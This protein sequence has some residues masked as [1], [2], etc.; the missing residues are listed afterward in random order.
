MR[1]GKKITYMRHTALLVFALTA[2][3]GC[4]ATNSEVVQLQSD[5]AT[6]KSQ[7]KKDADKI[8][9]LQQETKKSKRQLLLQGEG[10]K[11]E[12]KK[13]RA[14]SS[15]DMDGLRAEFSE[16]TGRFEETQHLTKR[17]SAD[18]SLFLESAEERLTA[19]ESAINAQEKDMQ[20]LYAEIDSLKTAPAPEP[21][22]A[23]T[24]NKEPAN[25][26]YKDALQLIRN[27][28]PGAARKLFKNYLKNYPDGPL[29]GNARFWVGES[30][31]D[32]KMYERAIVEYDDMIKKHPK[33]I[34]I[35]AALLKQAMAFDRLKDW[36]TAK[37][38]FDKLIKEFPGSEETKIAKNILKK[39]N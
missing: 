15:A 16:L 10:L 5:L 9:S 31:Y 38:L 8:A 25:K 35:P 39:R 19:I 21:P 4:I 2:G 29:A 37:A 7:Q 3:T 24:A 34:K 32:E 12:A 36:K 26:I 11:R 13:N 33:G 23:K 30:Y 20:K 27:K 1:Q 17:T 28:Q 6:L 18:L 22:K 14:G